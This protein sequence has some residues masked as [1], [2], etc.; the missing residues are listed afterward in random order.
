MS[1]GFP[2]R[3]N[4]IDIVKMISIAVMAKEGGRN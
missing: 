4:L 3:E 1:L 2:T